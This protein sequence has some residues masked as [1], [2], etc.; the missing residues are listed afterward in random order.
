MRLG[1]VCEVDTSGR[2]P[3][4]RGSRLTDR[5]NTCL[6]SS[7]SN[8]PGVSEELPRLTFL[9]HTSFL[10]TLHVAGGTKAAHEIKDRIEKAEH[11]EAE[12]VLLEVFALRF[13]GSLLLGVC[14]LNDFVGQSN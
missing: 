5:G 2:R 3:T 12:S 10:H 9:P 6:G 1:F 13:A 4:R 11:H 8:T 7:G 14:G